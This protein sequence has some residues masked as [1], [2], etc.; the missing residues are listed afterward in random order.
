M[1]R[2][3]IAYRANGNVSNWQ[4]FG[5][6]NGK[7]LTVSECKEICQSW[8]DSG[9][10]NFVSLMYEDSARAIKHFRA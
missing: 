10:W 6:R 8:I 7:L 2:T 1:Q 4:T 9:E 3:L 5:S